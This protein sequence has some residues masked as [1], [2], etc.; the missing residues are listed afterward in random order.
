MAALPG[1]DFNV[2]IVRKEVVVNAHPVQEHRLPLSNL[3]LTIPPVS[4]SLFLCYKQP[5]PRSV[6]SFA[7]E[8]THDLK[9]SLSEALSYYYVF[10][11][12]MVCNTSGEPELLCNNQGVEFVQAAANIG[13]AELDFYN[14]DK[15]IEGKLIPMLSNNSVFS[16]QVTKFSCG[17]III[18]C[19]FDH[20][21][22]DAFSTNMFLLSWAKL[23]RRESIEM[24]TPNFDRSVLLPRRR[25][26]YCSAIDE[27]YTRHSSLPLEKSKKQ[28]PPPSLVS[29][30]YYLTAKDVQFLQ[31]NANQHG[32]RYSKLVAFS[33]YLWKLLI[34][35]QE[36][37]NDRNCSIGVV[38]DGR[39]RLTNMG[40]PSNY[41]GNVLLLPFVEAQASDI[42]SKPLSWSAQLIHNVIFRAANEEHF[43]SLI[44]WV[45]MIRP[46]PGLATIYCK[47]DMAESNGPSILI[48]SGLR[49]PLSTIDFGWGNPCFGSYHFPCGGEAGYVMPLPSPLGDGSWVVYMHLPMN[50][51]EAIESHVD[52]PFRRITSNFLGMY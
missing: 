20:R 14:P 28:D 15:T 25:P 36:I 6:S 40:I 26:H 4:V 52:C 8:A 44:D 23:T 16:T 38:I 34:L 41:F 9:I 37:D 33:A 39:T 29:R 13:L 3:D 42:K 32:K 12:Q 2:K 18:G 43:Q 51:L 31:S 24:L 17:G 7:E 48:S 22:A 10:A 19:K 27:M 11:G 50:Q 35:S 49:F 46:D 1:D 47:R 45:E 30:I 21:I 5:N